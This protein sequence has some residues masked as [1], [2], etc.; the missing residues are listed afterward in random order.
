ML[1]RSGKQSARQAALSALGRRGVLVCAGHGEA[2]LLSVSE[3]LIAPERAVL[4]SE[5]FAFDELS[6]NLA[7]LRDNRDL[8]SRVITHT[9]D[10]RDIAGAFAV[11][12]SGES[13]K[14]VVTQGDGR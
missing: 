12:L 5:Y 11:F 6:R 9:F 1:F 14:V 8:I 10:V 7:L 3:D 2:L 4:G 13:G